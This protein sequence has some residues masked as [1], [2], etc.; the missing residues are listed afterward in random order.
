LRE[1]VARFTALP[2]TISVPSLPNLEP[3][4]RVRLG[5]GAV[6]LIERTVTCTYRDTV[7]V[8]PDGTLAEA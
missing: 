5:I 4:T 2:L 7:G 1:G 6:D 8:E 3:G